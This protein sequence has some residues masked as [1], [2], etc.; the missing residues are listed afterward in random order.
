MKKIL[1]II[2][3]LVLAAAVYSFIPVVGLYLEKDP[4]PY[5]NDQAAEKLKNN[6]GD[7]FEFIVLGDNH[8]G[9]IFNDSMTLKLIRSINREGRFKKDPYR[10][11]DNFRRYYIQRVPRGI[12]VFTI[13]Y[14]P[15][16]NYP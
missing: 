13:R 1:K 11:R 9:F 14:V 10:F 2:A 12:T 15:V 16:L 5:T 3:I 6:K 4:A 7:Y 8:A